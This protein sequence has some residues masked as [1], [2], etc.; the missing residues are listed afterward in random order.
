MRISFSHTTHA[1][2]CPEMSASDLYECCICQQHARRSLSGIL[3]HIREVHPHFVGRVPC[4]VEGCP[5]TPSSYE[6][7]RQHLC[8]NHKRLLTGSSSEGATTP[9]G[10]Q[11]GEQEEQPE[12]NEDGGQSTPQF[13]VNALEPSVPEQA[14]V[15]AQFIMKHRDGRKLTQVVTNGI[16]QDTKIILQSTI[17]RVQ[18]NVTEFIRSE[19]IQ[20][21]DQ[22]LVKFAAL[23]S[24]ETVVNPFREL[25]TEYMQQKF[26]Q[27]NFNYVVRSLSTIS[28]RSP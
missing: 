24:D 12:N 4:G 16:I 28:Y 22:Q 15:G 1:C 26:I 25:E 5:A 17:D 13:Q 14:I 23:F 9:A 19:K 18:K 11:V 2:S 8:R 6:G 3:R 27:E 7:L 10:S 20:L 21:T